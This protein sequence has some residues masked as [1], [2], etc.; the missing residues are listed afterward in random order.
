MPTT[1]TYMDA[2]QAA[3]LIS[4]PLDDKGWEVLKPRLLA[5]RADAAQRELR[6]AYS[7][8][9]VGQAKRQ[10]VEEEQ[11]V[12]Q[13]NTI[14]MWLGLKVPS[15]EKL[16]KFAE[17]FIHL[18]WSDGRAVTKATASKFAAEVLC[19]IRHRFDETIVQEDHMLSLKGTAF[20]QDPES[21]ACRKL[22]LLDMKWAFTEFV[23]PHTQRFGKDLFLCHVCD[24]NQKLF[25]F[26]A[27]IQHFASKHTNAF[28]HG[29]SIVF[30]EADWPIEPPFDPHPNLLWALGTTSSDPKGQTPQLSKSNLPRGLPSSGEKELG[31]VNPVGH[32]FPPYTVPNSYQPSSSYNPDN[33]DHFTAGFGI[34][35]GAKSFTR[36]SIARSEA[37]G[38]AKEDE[39]DPRYHTGW[40]PHRALTG[41][42]YRRDSFRSGGLGQRT[43]PHHL[44]SEGARWEHIR[45]HHGSRALE[46]WR[47]QPLSQSSMVYSYEDSSSRFSYGG[48]LSRVRGPR[49]ETGGESI[50]TSHISVHREKGSEPGASSHQPN[51]SRLD[52]DQNATENAVD[53]F[54]DSLEP[55]VSG[56]TSRNA[57]AR[58][59][60]LRPPAYQIRSSTALSGRVGGSP[61]QHQSWDTFSSVSGS[62]VPPIPPPAHR[63]SLPIRELEGSPAPPGNAATQQHYSPSLPSVH[64]YEVSRGPGSGAGGRYMEQSP[65]RPQRLPY[66]HESEEVRDGGSVYAE[67]LYQ[68]RYV[69]DR[70]GRKYEE[71]REMGIERYPDQHDRFS[72]GHQ[73]PYAPAGMHYLDG[74]YSVHRAVGH[75]ELAGT[76]PRVY[77]TNGIGYRFEQTRRPAF[78]DRYRGEE[79]LV[80]EHRTRT[81]IFDDRDVTYQ[82]IESPMRATA[83]SLGRSRPED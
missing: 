1:L 31:S 17:E 72:I 35:A 65:E 63:T 77:Q 2:F 56:D 10:Q 83:R 50:A 68:H 13:E 52:V 25:A 44:A 59:D 66:E 64:G 14:H 61:L 26:E 62:H 78:D 80:P 8:P 20:P 81:L 32:N 70:D 40:A 30:W 47:E 41:A 33:V 42:R 57:N 5:Q 28:S 48:S 46:P 73:E 54:L 39:H 60:I 43:G 27:I 45:D 22:N 67:P 6:A 69:Y 19:H 38:I 71:I 82:P 58:A 49:S 74:G 76:M 23:Q 12:A 3:I 21:L 37:S 75:E 53:E 15:R 79:Q 34:G 18:T 29:N 36:S 16:R 4:L 55:I 24:T 9:S 51:T 7:G 11:R